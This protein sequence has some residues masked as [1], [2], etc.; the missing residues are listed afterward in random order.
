[1][2]AAR[3]LTAEERDG[4]ICPW[5]DAPY[6]ATAGGVRDGRAFRLTR[7]PNCGDVTTWE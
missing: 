6:L 5:C 4:V 3:I 7:C 1:M 2:K